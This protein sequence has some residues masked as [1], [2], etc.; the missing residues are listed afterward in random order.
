MPNDR[1]QASAFCIAPGRVRVYVIGTSEWLTPTRTDVRLQ[2]G[3][4]R[5]R[6]GLSALTVLALLA[7]GCPSHVPAASPYTYKT[8]VDLSGSNY[9]VVKSNVVG[10][11][12]G[13]SLLL[14]IIPVSDPSYIEALSDLYEK[15]GNPQGK[16]YALANVS[17]EESTTQLILFSL[18][19]IT[20]RADII[21][22]TAPQ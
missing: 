20:I 21:E 14:G 10:T 9:R 6:T 12:S 17:Q 1:R 2:T 15:A 22:F 8:K 19:R 3:G 5:M 7:A 13:F 18:P 11:S 4:R 16:A